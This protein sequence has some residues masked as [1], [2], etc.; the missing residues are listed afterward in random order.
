MSEPASRRSRRGAGLDWLAHEGGGDAGVVIREQLQA[1]AGPPAAGEE[2]RRI[3]HGHIDP[4]PYQARRVFAASAMAELEKSVRRNG[5]LQ[6]VVVRPRP[7]GRYEL[8]AG[9]RRWRVVGV[10]GWEA[11]PAVV[12]MVDDLT[13]HLLGQ[14]END[15]RQDVSA[16]ERALGYVQMREHVARERGAVPTLAELGEMRGGVAKSTVS[17]YLTIGDAFPPARVAQA[18]IPEE[19]FATLALPPL[20]RAARKPE[21]Q[22]FA[23]LGDLLRKPRS[24]TAG[25]PAAAGSDQGANREGSA[26]EALA[27][28]GLGSED[29]PAIALGQWR[30]YLVERAI[31]LETAGP[32]QEMTPGQA[33]AAAER[34]VP[35]LAA[36]AARV[37]E[38]QEP[39][40]VVLAGDGGLVVFLPEQLQPAQVEV[41]GALRC[42]FGI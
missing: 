6:P 12:R 11:I 5:L 27:Q 30:R 33:R 38:A 24:R 36:L 26:Q 1:L 21:P 19:Q 17:R 4:S 35:A 9:E 32:A 31:R 20:L 18:G 2:V 37:A 39:S 41:L 40:A 16:W 22:R 13:A 23:M 7:G 28:R 3:P 25:K 29:R 34:I 15:D 10:L 14:V 8:V 42:Q